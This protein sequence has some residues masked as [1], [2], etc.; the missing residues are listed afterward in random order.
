MEGVNILVI[1]VWHHVQLISILRAMD[2]DLYI[3]ND[4]W[5]WEKKV[6]YKY[7]L[8]CLWYEFTMLG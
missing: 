1:V 4:W 7:A 8:L 5:Y 6:I 3:L 2:D